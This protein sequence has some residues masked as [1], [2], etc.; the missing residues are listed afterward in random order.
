MSASG[1]EHS[2]DDARSCLDAKPDPGGLTGHHPHVL[3]F[4][5]PAVPAVADRRPD[6]ISARPGPHPETA[7]SGVELGH[8]LPVGKAPN[9]DHQ[10]VVRVQPWRRRRIS[11][12]AR[13]RSRRTQQDEMLRMPS[14]NC[15]QMA[16][17][18]DY[19]SW[20]MD[21]A[22]CLARRFQRLTGTNCPLCRWRGWIASGLLTGSRL[23]AAPDPILATTD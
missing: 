3:G 13:S 21:L 11:G 4:A 20:R 1:L 17:L 23:G 7:L 9:S 22:L 6:A 10:V 2:C 18:P 19:A 15:W 14:G 12:T 16:C 8:Q 5:L